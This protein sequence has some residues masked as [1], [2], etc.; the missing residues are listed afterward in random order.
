MVAPPAPRISTP[1]IPVQRFSPPPAP[2]IVAPAVPFRAP[3]TQHLTVQ[4]RFISPG[5]SGQ[6]I[7]TQPHIPRLST[8]PAIRLHRQVLTPT[9]HRR[10][11][12]GVPGGAAPMIHR[13][14]TL[15]QVPAAH[16]RQLATTRLVHGPS[17]RLAVRNPILSTLPRHDPAHALR[18]STFHGAF[19]KGGDW[20]RDWRWHRHHH[21]HGRF[22]LGYIGPVFWPYAYTDFIDYTFWPSAYDTFWPYAFDDVYESIYGGYAPDIYPYGYVPRARGGRARVTA[23]APVCSGQTQGLTD[24]PIERI[25]GQVAPDQS[26]QALLDA[27]KAAT[28]QALQIMQSACPTELASTPTGRMAAMR[29]R[30]AAMLKAVQTVRPALDAFYAALNDEQKERFNALDAETVRSAAKD[31]GDV[32]QV[33]GSRATRATDLP[34]ARIERS[35]RLSAVQTAALAELKDA[36]AKAADTLAQSCSADQPLTPTGRLSAMEQR[37]DRLLQ[38]LDAVQ[39]AL[40]KFYDSLSD[41]QKARFNRLSPAA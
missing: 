38:A 30:V 1:S 14:I 29:E 23:A 11:I 41:E 5:L 33:C 13:R 4:P 12:G 22:V 40:T 19:A 18:R 24:L 9:I 17:G 25:A 16:V 2:R 3:A 21:R 35:L 15:G 6:R 28:Q 37:L 36:S 26:Q 39:P 10:A 7:V 27:L 34:F 32:S 20:K 31:R 8:T